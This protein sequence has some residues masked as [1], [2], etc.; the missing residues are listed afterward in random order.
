MFV[1][2]SLWQITE[3]L[4]VFEELVQGG[5]SDLVS[6][7]GREVLYDGLVSSLSSIPRV[8]N[9]YLNNIPTL[10]RLPRCASGKEPTCQCRRQKRCRFDPWVGKIPWR[11]TLQPTPVFLPGESHGRGAWKATVHRVAKS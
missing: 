2:E 1:S 8:I 4:M 11:R 5:W 3:K 9:V 10:C 7:S 6:H